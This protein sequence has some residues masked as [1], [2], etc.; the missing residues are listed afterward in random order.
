MIDTVGDLIEAL[1]AFPAEMP[2]RFYW[3]NGIDRAYDEVAPT[4]EALWN[5]RY[6]PRHGF[7]IRDDSE[8]GSEIRGHDYVHD[9]N[10][11]TAFYWEE[12]VSSEQV[13]VLVF[14]AED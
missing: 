13:D 11:G 9:A 10:K 5:V 2:V 12:R 6:R 3:E 14:A 7:T 4:V 8:V 1:K